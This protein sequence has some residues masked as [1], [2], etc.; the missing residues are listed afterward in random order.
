[1]SI[2]P[3]H[4]SAT[5]GLSALAELRAL[6]EKHGISPSAPSRVVELAPAEP[7]GPSIYEILQADRPN[8]LEEERKHQAAERAA[9]ERQRTELAQQ[10]LERLAE[11]ERATTPRWTVEQMRPA[12]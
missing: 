12:T 6:D 1:M 8:W 7:P 5:A 3:P 11:T 10:E 2:R 9:A 4:T